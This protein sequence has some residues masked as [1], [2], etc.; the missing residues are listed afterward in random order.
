MPVFLSI[1]RLLRGMV[2]VFT[3]VTLPALAQSAVWSE[4]L[5]GEHRSDANKA[6]DAYRHPAETLDF[7]GITPTSTVLEMYPGGGW[8]T[9][10][11]APVLANSGT[12]YAAHMGVNESPY[13]RRSLGAFLSKIGANSD[14]YKAVIVT[15]FNPPEALAIAPPNSVDVA[16]AFRNL[17]SWIRL[18]TIEKAFMAVYDSLKP[19]GIFGIV[20]HRGN[21]GMTVEQ[22]KNSGYVTEAYAIELAEL[23][24]FELVAKSEINANPKDTK[25]YERGVWTL[26]PSYRLGDQDREKYQEIGESDRMTLKF[27]KPE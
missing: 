3:M 8:Y 2:L 22:M 12:L 16:L 21:P 19:G 5:N 9:E 18:N 20:Q 25:D 4:A 26:P 27:R 6:R 13:A 11:L 24:G 23:V 14:L 15:E 17:H 7:F 10:V 1:H